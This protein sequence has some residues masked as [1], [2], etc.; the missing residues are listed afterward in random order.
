MTQPSTLSARMEAFRGRTVENRRNGCDHFAAAGLAAE[1]IGRVRGPALHVGTGHALM[2]STPAAIRGVTVVTVDDSLTD[3]NVAELVV[4]ES[5]LRNK[6][7]FVVAQTET[8]PFPDEHFGCAVM[9]D[10]ICSILR[11]RTVLRDLTRVLQAGASLLLGDVAAG[12]IALRARMLPEGEPGA[13]QER[14]DLDDALAMA[15]EQGF[16]VVVK[17]EG[18]LHDLAVRRKA[19]PNDPEEYTTRPRK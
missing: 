19:G 4:F 6:V 16:R 14:R 11:P 2:A 8:L 9:M 5:G 7:R 12:G 13:E 10:S 3:G 15:A 17:A 18:F 1:M